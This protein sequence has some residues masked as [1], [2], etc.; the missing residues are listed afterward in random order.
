MGTHNIKLGKSELRKLD[1][2]QHHLSKTKWSCSLL[3]SEY[4]L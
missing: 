3:F 2:L 1:W 4:I